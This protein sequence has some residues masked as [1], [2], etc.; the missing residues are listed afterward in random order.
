MM[1]GYNQRGQEDRQKRVEI[2]MEIRRRTDKAYLFSDGTR[3]VWISKAMAWVTDGARGI[4]VLEHNQVAAA[5]HL[6][7]LQGGLSRL[8]QGGVRREVPDLLAMT[9]AKQKE[10]CK[11]QQQGVPHGIPSRSRQ[12]KKVVFPIS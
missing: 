9:A 1:R 11:N 2:A 6:H 4:D 5:H 10:C 3:E 7:L 8:D 12:R